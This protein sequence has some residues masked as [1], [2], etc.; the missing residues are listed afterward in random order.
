MSAAT[1]E[2]V[3]ITG[4][5]GLIGSNVC[6]LLTDQGRHVR[7][8]VRPGSE[9]EPLA[10]LGVE[11]V[12]G[13]I[14]SRDDVAR[15]AQGTSA[16]INSAALLGGAAQDLAA[17]QATNYGGS[18][19]CYEVAAAGG[20]R[21]IELA[22]TTFLVHDEPLNEHPTVRSE[23]NDD[24]YSLSK[25][26][27]FSDGMRRA[28]EG[29]DVVFVIP[30]GTFGPSPCPKRALSATSYNRLVRAAIRGRLT[31]YVSY[32]VPWVLAEDVARVVVGAVDRGKAGDTY[33]AFG[34]EDAMTTAAFLNVACEVV[35]TENRIA[36]VT[37]DPA[38]PAAAE[39]YGSTLVALA[40]HRFPVPWFDNSY[41][42]E[43]LGYEP[44]SLR[45][46]MEETV[47]WLFMIGNV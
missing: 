40:Q 11:L 6:R 7:A 39:R 44:V 31:D 27:A 20:L 41:T 8:L 9:T 13:D 35:G 38:D 3:M 15:A 22:T 33:L 47:S 5:T 24:P 29:Q 23:I 19:H 2:S 42:R 28:N 43:L 30:G 45:E 46:A 4:A 34:R 10:E 1:A 16:L 36:E 25:G 14:T 18:L 26:A 17:S 37:I 32:P 21:V 12:F